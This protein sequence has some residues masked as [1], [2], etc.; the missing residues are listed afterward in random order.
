[1]SGRGNGSCLDFRYEMLK[2]KPEVMDVGNSVVH[3]RF[4][5]KQTKTNVRLEL[6]SRKS[7]VEAVDS[8]AEETTETDNK[9]LHTFIHL[10]INGGAAGRGGVSPCT[11]CFL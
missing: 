11:S 3:F 4:K 7:S 8:P 2:E 1:M 9:S 10:D 5:K 6:H